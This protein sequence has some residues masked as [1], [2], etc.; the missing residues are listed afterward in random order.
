MPPR[1]HFSRLLVLA[2]VSS[3][4]ILPASVFAQAGLSGDPF[5]GQTEE[6]LQKFDNGKLQS[7]SALG[8]LEELAGAT[9]DRSSSSQE[10]VTRV[11]PRPKP[12]QPRFD[13]NQMIK[14]QVAGALA[15]ALIGA[16]FSDNSAQEEVAAEAAA[17]AAAEAAAQAGAFRVQ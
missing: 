6:R 15:D 5:S 9:V 16:L 13:T 3:F 7:Q 12:V 10:T 11:A 4:T 8:Q 2:V 1:C 17:Q 14:Q